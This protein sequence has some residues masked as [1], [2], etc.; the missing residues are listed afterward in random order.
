[1]KYLIANWKSNKNLDQALKWIREYSLDMMI[2]D[3]LKS[4]T[5]HNKLLTIVICPPAI[6]I[7]G[8]KPILGKL[9]KIGIQNVSSKDEGSF[10][11]ELNAKS[12]SGLIDYA[13]IG[14]SERRSFFSETE[15]EIEDKI[16]LLKEN[17][18]KIILCIRNDKDIIYEGVDIVAYEPVEAIGTGKSMSLDDI[19][20]EKNKLKIPKDIAFVY[21]GSVNL[22]NCE[23]YIKSD[24][25]DGL[26]VGSASLDER[27]F[28][29]ITKNVANTIKI[30]F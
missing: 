3:E 15:K 2:C 24:E 11:G 9:A 10:T 22:A 18:I 20:K 30:Q 6:F 27:G 5:V 16:K 17:N 13:I 19:I 1:M 23:E 25:I 28:F 8:S 26:L 7:S 4:R 14:H 12:L 29:Q 21:G